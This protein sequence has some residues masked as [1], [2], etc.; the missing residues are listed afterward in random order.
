MRDFLT[1]FSD[2]DYSTYVGDE[3]SP[4]DIEKATS[5]T[6]D[7]YG[8][9]ARTAVAWCALNAHFDGRT[10]DYQFWC[11]IFGKLSAL[12]DIDKRS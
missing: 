1:Y 6:I 9:D 3:G 10:L 8:S 2:S 12:P 11:K 7:R 4:A 5:E